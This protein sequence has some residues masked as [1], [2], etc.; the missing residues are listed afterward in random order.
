[1]SGTNRAIVTSL[2]QSALRSRVNKVDIGA[3]SLF[4]PC[5][6]PALSTCVTKYTLD[7]LFDFLY[8]YSKPLLISAYDLYEE[9]HEKNHIKSKMEGMPENI[10][11]LD[12]GRFESSW[13]NSQDWSFE[14]YKATIKSTTHDLYTSFDVFPEEAG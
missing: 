6:F 3:K 13:F 10:L 14:R 4:T 1:M 7:S 8:Q 9:F 11:F 5:Y 2:Y 12:S